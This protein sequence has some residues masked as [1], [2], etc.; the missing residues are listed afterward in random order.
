MDHLPPE[1][2]THT[3]V[4]DEM[5]PD[6]LR[7]AR[8]R[9]TGKHGPWSHAEL[10]QAEQVDTLRRLLHVVV[11]GFGG[12]S[13]TPTPWPRPGIDRPTVATSGRGGTVDGAAYIARLRAEHRAMHGD[14]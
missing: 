2:A 5:T 4:R 14:G 9:D 8:G 1:S 12:K 11:T 10:I 13:D 7:A 6:D 3:A